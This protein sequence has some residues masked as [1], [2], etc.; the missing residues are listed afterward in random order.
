[1]SQFI[2]ENIITF[3]MIVTLFVFFG[4]IFQSLKLKMDVE[5]I[6]TNSG[7]RSYVLC[8]Q[9]LEENE[10][11]QE[12]EKLDISNTRKMN[13]A[14]QNA[15]IEWHQFLT[16]KIPD[17]SYILKISGDKGRFGGC[18]FTLKSYLTVSERVSLEGIQTDAG[19]TKIKKRLQGTLSLDFKILD[20]NFS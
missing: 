19:C 16:K 15:K 4:A 9:L 13:L 18:F 6:L 12:C 3:L 2:K 20:L 17:T 5:S 7:E 10:V 8:K 11:S 14:L 1:M